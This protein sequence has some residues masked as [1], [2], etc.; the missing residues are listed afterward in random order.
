M[1]NQ[2]LFLGDYLL[3]PFYLVAAIILL[4][5]YFRK[6]HGGNLVLKKYFNWGLYLKLFGCIAISMIYQYYYGGSY[7]GRYYFMGAKV[8][9]SYLLDYP[10]DFFK[11]L[12]GDLSTFNTSNKAGINMKTV[13]IFAKESFTVSKYAAIF[14]LFTFNYFLPCAVFFCT[15]AF[16]G[17]WNFFIF[18]I[19]EFNIP[20]KTAAYCS[21]YIP[22]VLV[23]GSGI[24]KD[25]ISFTGLLYMFICS[26]YV[27]IKK[28][29]VLKNILGIIISTAVVYYIKSYIVAAFVPFFIIYIINSNKAQIKNPLLRIASTPL[30]IALGFGSMAIFLQYA[31]ELFGRYSVDQVLETASQT[32]YY[33]QEISSGSAYTLNVDLS[34]PAG[35]LAA[36]PM[37]INLTLFRPYPWEYLKPIILFASLESMLFLYFTLKIVFKA[38]FFKLLAIV[39]NSP[40]IQFCLFFSLTFAFMVGLSSGNFGTLVRYKIPLMPFYLLFLAVFYKEVKRPKI[41]KRKKVQ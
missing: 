29:K 31:D 20:P 17:L 19:E 38:G 27:F 9:T 3:L 28:K 18:I 4:N 10:E 6:R 40:L 13:H 14:N 30:M 21:L 22:S 8:L 24:F 35:V 7:D 16:I 5:I 39:L 26:Y 11:V 33:I 36:I 2:F 37:A 23:W 12:F 25:T 41:S 32:A 1:R 34:S 15:T